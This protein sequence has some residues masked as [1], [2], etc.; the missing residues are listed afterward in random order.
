[1]FIIFVSTQARTL[2][3]LS[4]TALDTPEWK[5]ENNASAFSFDHYEQMK[6]LM[7]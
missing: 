3:Y 2:S 1:M 7:Y 6:R 4:A 5:P